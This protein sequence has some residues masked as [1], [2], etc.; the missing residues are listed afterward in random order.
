VAMDK[1]VSTFKRALF[2]LLCESIKYVNK[3]EALLN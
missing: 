2:C 3:K 1:R